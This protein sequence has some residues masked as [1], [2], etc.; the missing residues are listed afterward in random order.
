MLWLGLLVLTG[1][2]RIDF[3]ARSDS[4]PVNDT[5]TTVSCP[6]FAVFCDDFE[7]G[8]LSRWTRIAT[9]GQGSAI[10]GSTRVR[11]GRFALE[12]TVLASATPDGT[13]APALTIQA[14]TSG[15]LAVRA[16]LNSPEPLIN[17]DLV[18]SFVHQSSP[19]YVSLGGDGNGHWTSTEDGS[20]A[21]LTN[22]MTSNA[23]DAIIDHWTCVE[24]VY[25]FLSGTAAHI[26]AFADNS[27][28]L[29]ADA[30]DPTPIFDD[31]LVGIPRADKGG[32]HVFVDDVVVADQRIGCD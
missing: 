11:G 12:S 10:V 3:D 31:V 4:G 19:Q 15:I 27:L 5:T 16:W 32:Y 1:C 26:Q 24:L 25:A 30:V 23:D 9:F 29:D 22:H 17:F 7:T 8:D 21:G 14:R 2:G 28:V 20:P 6:A 13:Q 18:L